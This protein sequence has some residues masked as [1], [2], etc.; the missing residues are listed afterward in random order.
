MDKLYTGL[1]FEIF[2]SVL[3]FEG[4]TAVT[5]KNAASWEIETKF[6]PQVD[7]LLRYRDRPVK[8]M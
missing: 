2:P 4:F 1:W 3:R 5:M 7:T 8:T 6:V